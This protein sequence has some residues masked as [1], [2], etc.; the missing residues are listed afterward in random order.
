MVPFISYREIHQRDCMIRSMTAI[1]I[2]KDLEVKYRKPVRDVRN[3]E[4]SC[5]VFS[6]HTWKV[7]FS[8]SRFCD[9]DS[10]ERMNENEQPMIRS[11][12]NCESTIAPSRI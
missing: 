2:S 7:C 10:C 3:D 1:G 6:C 12:S 4:R 5:Q 9:G 11:N 8:E